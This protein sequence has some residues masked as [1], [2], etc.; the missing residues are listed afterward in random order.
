MIKSSKLLPWELESKSFWPVVCSLLKAKAICLWPEVSHLFKT[1][2]LWMYAKASPLCFALAMLVREQVLRRDSTR[3]PYFGSVGI[4]G[5]TQ[6]SR[7][8]FK[9]SRISPHISHI[10]VIGCFVNSGGFLGISGDNSFCQRI[11]NIYENGKFGRFDVVLK[12]WIFKKAI[13]PSILIR[14]WSLKQLPT[15][16]GNPLSGGFQNYFFPFNLSLNFL[17]FHLNSSRTPPNAFSVSWRNVNRS[18]KMID[19]F[20]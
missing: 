15:N 20:G 11:R 14:I 18:Y 17:K 7:S 13:Y 5:L 10:Y 6:I 4:M 8:R 2:G 3:R 1:V 19:M 12:L 16:P 9:K